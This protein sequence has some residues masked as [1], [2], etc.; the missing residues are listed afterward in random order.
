MLA[1]DFFLGT[2]LY[3]QKFTELCKPLSDY[4]GD[5]T[6][7]QYVNIDKDGTG[8]AVYSLEK[9]AE[10]VLEKEYYKTEIGMVHPNNMHNGFS[11]CDSSDYQEYKDGL[12]Y[13][14]AVNFN[15]T[16][17]FFYVEKNANNDGYFGSS[18]CLISICATGPS[19]S[20][21]STLDLG[22]SLRRR[23]PSASPSA[24]HV[25]HSC[26]QARLNAFSYGSTPCSIFFAR[27]HRLQIRFAKNSTATS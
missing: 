11:F 21:L 1:D 5:I 18:V 12:L 20:T 6:S 16:H 14:G 2:K 22:T 27:T 10:R 15:W 3:Q 26:S 9:W 25:G 24:A 13:D 7:V 19:R 4:L 23:T 8:F 17:S